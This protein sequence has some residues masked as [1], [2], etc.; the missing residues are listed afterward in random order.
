LRTS[1]KV[2]HEALVIIVGVPVVG[3]LMGGAY[4]LPAIRITKGRDPWLTI[5]LAVGL[6]ITVLGIGIIAR[7]PW[8]HL[9]VVLVVGGLLLV[10]MR[11]LFGSFKGNLERFGLVHMA[12]LLVLWIVVLRGRVHGRL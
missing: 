3:I 1:P 9:A 11:S 8:V 12:T 5:L 7:E 10:A 4:S 2:F 6:S